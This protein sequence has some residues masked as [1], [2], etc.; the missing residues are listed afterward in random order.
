[1]VSRLSRSEHLT[2]I[3]VNFF[4]LNFPDINF[5]CVHTDVPYS[6]RNGFHGT[7]RYASIHTHMGIGITVLSNLPFVCLCV[8]LWGQ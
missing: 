3:C 7:P 6:T 5:A 8:R 2:V 1:M 4:K